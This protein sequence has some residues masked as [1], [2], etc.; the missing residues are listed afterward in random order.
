MPPAD[1]S[2]SAW[3]DYF[4]GQLRQVPTAERVAGSVALCSRLRA[5]TVWKKAQAILF[6]SPMPEEPDIRPLMAEAWALG[7][8]V[9]LPRSS[10]EGHYDFCQIPD[11]PGAL[12][13][14][15]FGILE[16]SPACPHFDP[17]QLDLALVP[18]IGF[19]L[20]GGRMGRGRGY[21]DRLLAEVPG[22][23]C[24]VAFDGQVTA[25]LPSEPHDIH[26]N[27]ILTPTRWHAVSGPARS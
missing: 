19:S 23:K 16:P 26:L 3:R 17:K 1:A 14:G 25:E 20:A 7:R 12:Q 21:Y 6:F 22:F 4:R 10:L 11:G 8:Q 5:Q 24:G 18:G 2:K 13:P 9:V 15:R 27:C